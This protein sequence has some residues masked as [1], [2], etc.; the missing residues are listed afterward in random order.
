MLRFI[1]F[2]QLWIFG[3]FKVEQTQTAEK[4]K[5]ITVRVNN[6]P[7][8]FSGNKVTGLQIKEA[9]ISQNVAI[10]SDFQLFEKHGE[11]KLKLIP[12]NELIT[13]HDNEEFRA[14]APDDNS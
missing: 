2:W 7:V 12:D 3:G 5:V 1:S 8:T 9:A 10:Q 6:K 13:I 11:G 4:V 14:T